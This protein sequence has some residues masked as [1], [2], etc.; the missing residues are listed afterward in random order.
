MSTPCTTTSRIPSRRRSQCILSTFWEL[1]VPPAVVG[2]L[3]EYSVFSIETRP[4]NATLMARRWLVA[5]ATVHGA[6]EAW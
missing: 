5:E 1:A 4:V 2:K 6:A 3:V